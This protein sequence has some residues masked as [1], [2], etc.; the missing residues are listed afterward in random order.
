MS[1]NT[2]WGSKMHR[3][4]PRL[5]NILYKT[6]N[7]L[8]LST[9]IILE[10]QTA[11]YPHQILYLKQP[12]KMPYDVYP[13]LA[14]PTKAYGPSPFASSPPT[15]NHTLPH[16]SPPTM[17]MHTRHCSRIEKKTAGGLERGSFVSICYFILHALYRICTGA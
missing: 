17:E 14:P 16:L 5:H 7:T 12:L 9:T 1:I 10:I 3:V 6:S 11:T 8:P 4:F 2:G 15:Q 13:A